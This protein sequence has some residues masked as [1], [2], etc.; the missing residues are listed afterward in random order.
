[1]TKQGGAYYHERTGERIIADLTATE[2]AAQRFRASVV[3]GE[4]ARAATGGPA[5]VLPP[6]LVPVEQIGD[7]PTDSVNV[8]GMKM[9]KP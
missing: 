3:E 8:T 7:E 9:E 1:M 2:A 4:I 5:E 6:P